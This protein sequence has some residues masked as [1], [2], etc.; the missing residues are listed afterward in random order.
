MSPEVAVKTPVLV[1]ED[2][3]SVLSFVKAALD[4]SGYAVAPVATGAVALTLLETDMAPMSMPGSRPTNLS[5]RRA[6]FSS[7]ATS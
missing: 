2:E 3:P 7:P 6:L 4:R 1:I 5:L